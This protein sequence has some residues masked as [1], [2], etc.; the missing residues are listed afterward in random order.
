MA[1]LVFI[2][3]S[4][5]GRVVFTLRD[6]ELEVMTQ[7]FGN[8]FERKIPIRS[9]ATD[10]HAVAHR[11][12]RLIVLFLILAGVC[13]FLARLAFTQSVLPTIV[14]IYPTMFAV[15]FAAGAL[16]FARRLEGY[17]FTDRWQRPLFVILR[18]HDQI[19]ECDA[20]VRELLDRIERQD[21]GLPLGNGREPPQRAA[22]AVRVGTGEGE[23]A[24]AAQWKRAIIAGVVA[25]GYPL[26]F[27][28]MPELAEFSLPVFIVASTAALM[29]SGL[30]FVR[31][32][33]RKYWSLLGL[34]L[35][36]IPIVLE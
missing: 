10:Y 11:S 31:N 12:T 17:Q 3:R 2:Q 9:I 7:F 30:S 4:R 23:E 29:T 19:E 13:I 32:E 6:D 21:A 20:F 15:G 33:P 18:E 16:A 24:P 14:G 8:R 1:A 35:C 22:S 27:F 28:R 5:L 34:A 25:A 36:A 26:A